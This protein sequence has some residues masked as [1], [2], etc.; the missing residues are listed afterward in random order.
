[1]E[2]QSAAKGAWSFVQKHAVLLTLILVLVLQFVPNNEGALPWGGIWMRMQVKELRVADSAAASSVEAFLDQQAAAMARQQYPNL[3]ESNRQK[4]INDVKKK[5]REE[6]KDEL[7]R[8]EK[9]L[10]DEIRDQYSYEV[11]GRKFGYMPDI[12]PY[13]Y[14]RYARNIVEKGHWY[15]VMNGDVPWDNHMFAPVGTYADPNWHSNVL[16]WLHRIFSIFDKQIP[17][18]E[19]AT[20]FPIVFIFLSLIFAFFITQR[21]AGNLGGFFAVTMLAIMPAVMGRT[22][23]GHADTDAYNIF[24]PLLVVWLLFRALSASSW[25]KQSVWAGLAGAAIGLYSNFWT[26]YWYLLDFVIGAFV[27]AMLVEIVS[28]LSR[29]REWFGSILK[30]KFFVTG[31]A[32]IVVTAIVCSSTIG[33]EKFAND[34]SGG[35]IGFTGIKVATREDLWPNVFTTVAELNPASFGD[36]LGSVGGILMFFISALGIVMLLAKKDADGKFDVTYSALLAIW[37]FGTIY[38]ALKGVRFTLLLGPA[39]AVAFGVAVGLLYRKLSDIGERQF[40]IRKIVTGILIVVILGIII[41]NPTKAGAHMVRSSYAAVTNDIPLVND[42]WWNTLTKIKENSAPNAIVNSWWDFGHHFKYI[43]DRAVTFD[44]STQNSPQAHWVGKVLQT[45]NEEEAIAILR[46]LDCGANLAYETAVNATNDPLISVNLVKKIIM[47]DKETATQ[48]AQAAGVPESI[49]SF[50]HCDPPE[51]YFITSGDM[52]GKAGVWAHFGLW[53][54]ER[55]EVWQKWKNMDE[56]EAVPK[57]AE[58]FDM[59]KEAATQLYRDA[60]ALDSEEAAN[61]WISPWPGYVTPDPM[62]CS[63]QGDLARCGSVAVNMSNMNAQ[64]K[65]SQGI[66]QA[67]RV[68]VYERDGTKR[69]VRSNG[70]ENVAVVM[71]QDG[72]G[73]KAISVYSPLADSMFTRLYYLHGLGL[74]HFKPF[75]EERQLIGGMVY[76]WKVDWQGSEP[77]VQPKE[78][79]SKD[80]VKSGATVELNYIGWTDDNQMFDSSIVGWQQKNI[81]KSA[82]FDDFEA[83]PISVPIGQGK[84]IAGFENAVIGMKVGEEK[85]ITIPPEQAYGTDP[86]KHPLGNK[87][88]HFKIRVESIK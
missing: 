69:E 78:S 49:V 57:M 31:L 62:P 83:K 85:T 39:F 77:N 3:P 60:I 84:L 54:F 35:A 16:A 9:R 46:M 6:N 25:K 24:F 80:V 45:E 87:T 37:F 38:A 40:H 33:W 88:L 51:D 47:Q 36:V 28:N 58:R 43:S 53:D 66:A 63:R 26:G 64:V 19:S 56:A 17:L 27:V 70:N 65:V 79:A 22:L 12:D 86:T 23:W 1:M 71:W 73:V 44:G 48:T 8:E 21:L 29:F 41:A 13:F 67:G 75:S 42:A 72:D 76:A 34:V 32:F 55:A 82:G 11:D 4:V 50:T 18:M 10:A 7:E 5:F 68:I 2:E 14:L 61:Q 30:N 20:Y 74:R 81:S 52:I 15:D 59:T